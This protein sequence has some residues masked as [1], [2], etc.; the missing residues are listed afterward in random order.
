MYTLLCTIAEYLESS[1]KQCSSVINVIITKF[2]LDIEGIASN[3]HNS[4]FIE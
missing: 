2:V 4:I 3:N 1:V